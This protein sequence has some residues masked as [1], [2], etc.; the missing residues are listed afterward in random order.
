[1]WQ[2]HTI[3]TA[4]YQYYDENILSM[5]RELENVVKKIAKFKSTH[6]H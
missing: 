3:E 1:M 2:S 5:G 4:N 6:S